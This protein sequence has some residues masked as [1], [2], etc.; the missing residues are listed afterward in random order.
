MKLFPV[1]IVLNAVLSM[2]GCS[3][4]RLSKDESSQWSAGSAAGNQDL[5]SVYMVDGVTG[6]AVGDMEP[7]PSGGV[8]YKTT[9]GGHTWRPVSRVSEILTSVYFAAPMVGWVVGHGGRIEKT[10]DGGITWKPQRVEREAEILNSIQFT[11]DRHGWVAGGE[12]LLLHTTNGGQ[13]WDT[14]KTG[15]PEDLWC[16]RFA[17]PQKGWMV[18]E[19][20]LLLATTDGGATWVS[21]ASGVTRALLGLAVDRAGLAVAVGASGTVLRSA[22][23]NSWIRAE[24][25]TSENL[26]AVSSAGSGVFW[27]VGAHGV[28]LQS[29]DGGA[30]WRVS[31]PLTSRD[32]LAIDVKPAG[33]GIAVGQKGFTQVLSE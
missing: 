29:N 13:T 27:A 5:L 1:L 15:R 12:G 11:D 24:S 18:G 4:G 30:T 20:G 31:V 7:G 9:D 8:I 10:E 28:S 32:L 23:G 2:S 14:I 21:A 33:H 26:N 3:R 25:G 22:D 19:G 17:S 16:V 6:W